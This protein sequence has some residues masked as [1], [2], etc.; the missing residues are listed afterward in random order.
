MFL[1]RNLLEGTTEELSRSSN[2]AVSYRKGRK[3]SVK[4]SIVCDYLWYSQSELDQ[5]NEL[6][7]FSNHYK[8]RLL[9]SGNEIKDI[10]ED[11]NF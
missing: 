8:E 1:V 9:K 5:K 4:K 3:V 6:T 10:P 11:I 7:L 2:S